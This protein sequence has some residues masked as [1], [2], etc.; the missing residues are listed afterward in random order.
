MSRLTPP[1]GISGAFLL[2]EPFVADPEKSYTVVAV[3]QFYELISRGQDPVEL[4]Y[5][6]V[7]LGDTAYKA[8]QAIGALVICLRDR[9]GSLLYVPDTYIDQYPNMGSVVYSRLVLGVNLG[10]WPDERNVDDILQAVTESVASKIG[11]EPQ[12]IVTRAP[13]QDHV[14]EE[15]HVQLLA[16]RRAAVTHQETDTATIIRLSDEIAHLQRIID[17]QVEIINEL[18]KAQTQEV[19]S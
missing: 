12:V 15:Q 9:N 11:V 2:R 6:P 13:T 18:V 17:E 14:T 19:T 16:A 3:R 1:M 4:V 7:G 10:M 8:D 5:R